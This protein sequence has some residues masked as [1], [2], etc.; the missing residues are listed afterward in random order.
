MLLFAVSDA[1]L[2][3][4]IFQ[5]FKLLVCELICGLYTLINKTLLKKSL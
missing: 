3:K 5:N 2:L 1:Q 4:A